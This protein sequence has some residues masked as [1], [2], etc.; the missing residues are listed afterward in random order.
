[1]RSVKLDLGEMVV[2]LL[3]VNM[4]L[5]SQVG[6]EGVGGGGL[7]GDRWTSISRQYQKEKG[8]LQVAT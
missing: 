8:L 7:S 1:M 6:C 5:C 4:R 2:N 3:L